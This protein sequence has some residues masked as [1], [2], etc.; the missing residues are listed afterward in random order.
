MSPPS[1]WEA[2]DK[3]LASHYPGLEPWSFWRN[4]HS[5]KRTSSVHTFLVLP[6]QEPTHWVY[7]SV[8]HRFPQRSL[9][10]RSV[11]PSAG[12]EL[13]LRLPRRPE[14]FIPPSWP[15]NVLSWLS[16]FAFDSSSHLTPGQV[17]AL[18]NLPMKMLGTQ[19]T[20]VLLTADPILGDLEASNGHT[21]FL[22][23]VGITEDE[24]EAIH[25]WGPDSFLQ[26][27]AEDEP[28]RLWQLERRSILED[29]MMASRMREELERDG[30]SIIMEFMP[31]LRMRRTDGQEPAL[32]LMLDMREAYVFARAL[33]TRTRHH[34]PFLV[35]TRE[36]SLQLL[37]ALEGERGEFLADEGEGRQP[38]LI[39]PPQRID[40][41]LEG[42]EGPAGTY[43]WPWFPG[44]VLHRV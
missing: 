13:T 32:E 31:G 17:V 15:M 34:R 2:L 6:V 42:F 28:L 43:T 23:V 33:R 36:A 22:Q 11:T 30:S 8:S 24:Q 40:A 39:I 14:E 26:L 38:C 5:R 1:G 10:N 16:D 7:L 18:A 12:S 21:R 19:L 9:G 3:H 37:P 41:L 25:W 20:S 29:P 27:L 35:R 44:L 4:D